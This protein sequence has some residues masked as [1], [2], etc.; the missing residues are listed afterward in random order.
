MKGS[1]Y[2]SVEE[3]TLRVLVLAIGAV[4]NSVTEL[5]DLD[6]NIVI[7]YVFGWTK[8]PWRTV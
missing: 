7:V 8:V 6:A 2:R 4:G 5:V 1:A 3:A